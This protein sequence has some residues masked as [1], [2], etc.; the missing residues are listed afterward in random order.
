MNSIL[1]YQDN[2]AHLGL[3]NQ[4]VEVHFLDQWAVEKYLS[5]IQVIQSRLPMK[6]FWHHSYLPGLVHPLE[7]ESGNNFDCRR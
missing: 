7:P 1:C 5:D 4:N 6:G 2:G 3:S